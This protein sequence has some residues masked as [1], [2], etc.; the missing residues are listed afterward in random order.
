MF[1]H[2]QRG[3]GDKTV[4]QLEKSMSSKLETAVARQIQTQFQ[5]T[6][7]QVLQEAINSASS[8]TQNLTTELIDGQRKLLAL[9]AAGNTKALSPLAM[10][11]SNGSTT[12]LPEI[13]NL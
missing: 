5:T 3:V 9:V 4:N 12:G 1:L 13:V 7:K 8:I 2:S 10:Q 6:G 11:Q